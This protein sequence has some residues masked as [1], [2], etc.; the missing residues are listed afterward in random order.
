MNVHIDLFVLDKN[1]LHEKLDVWLDGGLGVGT[2]TL[3]WEV[4]LRT[5]SLQSMCEMM[6]IHL[7]QAQAG[8]FL[9]SG[10]AATCKSLTFPASHSPGLWLPASGSPHRSRSL[11]NDRFLGIRSAEL[12]LDISDGVTAASATDTINPSGS[13]PMMGIRIHGFSGSA[14]LP[15]SAAVG[16]A[17]RP[18]AAKLLRTWWRIVE[19]LHRTDVSTFASHH[20]LSCG[21]PYLGAFTASS[22]AGSSSPESILSIIVGGA[23]RFW[24]GS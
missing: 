2:G 9:V 5:S 7:E 17:S 22:Y 6:V 23:S 3:H 20:A 1:G 16:G 11:V 13:R 15:R 12:H 10:A 8:L 19:S 24:E 14:A 18:F 21:N 4:S